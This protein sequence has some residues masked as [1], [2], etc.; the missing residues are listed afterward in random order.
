[1]DDQS[2]QTFINNTVVEIG[3]MS[4][5]FD[6]LIGELRYSGGRITTVQSLLEQIDSEFQF[7]RNMVLNCNL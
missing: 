1:M 7:I 5:D 6:R 3:K 2:R 4:E